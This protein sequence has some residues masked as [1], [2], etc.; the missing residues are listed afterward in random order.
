MKNLLR[1]FVGIVLMIGAPYLLLSYALGWV[2]GI[3]F[4]AGLTMFTWLLLAVIAVLSV[5]LLLLTIMLIG[6]KIYN[7]ESLR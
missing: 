1:K 5:F 4:Y 3:P 7:G 6:M 2:L